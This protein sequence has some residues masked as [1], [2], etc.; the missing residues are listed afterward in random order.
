[1]FW[2]TLYV[3]GGLVLAA[4]YLPQLR[5]FSADTDGLK[6][7]SLPKAVVQLACRAA[8]MPFVWLTVESPTMLVLQG[9]DLALRAVE[10]Q[11]ALA[12]LRRQGWTWQRIGARLMQQWA[13]PTASETTAL[14]PERE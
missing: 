13:Q 8:M 12:T 1:M 11:M 2:E 10:V 7:Y 9:M 5:T 3:I 4:Y 6:A 14:I